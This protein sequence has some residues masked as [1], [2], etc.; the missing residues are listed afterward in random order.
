MPRAPW[1]ATHWVRKSANPAELAPGDPANGLTAFGACAAI[2][3]LSAKVA[4]RSSSR[5]G[6]FEAEKST[7]PAARTSPAPNAARAGMRNSL[8]ILKATPLR[9]A[10]SFLETGALAPKGNTPRGAIGSRATIFSGFFQLADAPAVRRAP[11]SVRR[12]ANPFMASLFRDDP[13]SYQI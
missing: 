5:L 9:M 7:M 2:D 1:Q 6:G 12:T 8:A 4:S 3:R 10:T 13:R 11:E